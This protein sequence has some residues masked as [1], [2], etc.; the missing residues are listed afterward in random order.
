MQ[1][2]ANTTLMLE[3]VN[4]NVNDEDFDVSQCYVNKP[5]NFYVIQFGELTHNNLTFLSEN[6]Q[7]FKS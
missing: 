2:A 1:L 4:T 5:M 6:F 7:S 3:E